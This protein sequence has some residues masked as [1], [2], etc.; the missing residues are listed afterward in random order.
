MDAQRKRQVEEVLGTVSALFFQEL[1]GLARQITDYG[2]DGKEDEKEA[3][4][5]NKAPD[6]TG[7]PVV[8][9]DDESDGDEAYV[10]EL[11]EV[12]DADDRDP[13]DELQGNDKGITMI[14]QYA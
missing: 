14:K 1:Y 6:A 3:E 4:D 10:N 2:T 9:E 8:F 12:E 7:V 11:D 13:E 5:K